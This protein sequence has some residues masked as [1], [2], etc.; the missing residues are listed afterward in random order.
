MKYEK[1]IRCKSCE[2]INGCNYDDD[3][4]NCS[5][6]GELIL[7]PND[8]PDVI[9]TAYEF[10]MI[11]L[12]NHYK[13]L[14]N[15][16][17]TFLRKYG[18]TEPQL[19]PLEYIGTDEYNNAPYNI[20]MRKRQ[21]SKYVNRYINHGENAYWNNGLSPYVK[22]K[23][24]MQNDW[25]YDEII[26][27]SV[28]KLKYS[29]FLQTLYWQA[30]ADYKRYESEYMCEICKGTNQKLSVHHKSYKRH[31]YEHCECVYQNDLTVLC[32]PCHKKQHNREGNGE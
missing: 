4:I 12:N 14:S 25:I 13:E 15:D 29:D 11:Y 10:E 23:I 3:E 2:S 22:S 18:I 16:Y 9:Y 26:A 21:T 8:E 24:I 19:I 20:E 5:D 27:A 7:Y 32:D 31:G 17:S 1:Y 6:C 30:I 28:N